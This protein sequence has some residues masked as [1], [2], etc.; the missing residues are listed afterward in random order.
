MNLFAITLFISI[1][2]I[3][4]ISITLIHILNFSSLTDMQDN[5]KELLLEAGVFEGRILLNF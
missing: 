1:I 2:I 3:R 5:V 4:I